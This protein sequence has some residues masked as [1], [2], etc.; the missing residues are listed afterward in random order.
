[1]ISDETLS[2]AVEQRLLMPAQVERLRAMEAET[3]GRAT[4]VEPAEDE[5]LRF[6]TGFADIFV[7]IGVILFLGALAFLM[8]AG[9]GSTP[10]FAG[11]AC[12][13]WLLAEFFTGKRRMALPSIVLLIVF[14][15]ASFLVTLQIATA[16]L[17]ASRPLPDRFWFVPVSNAAA[18]AVAAIFAVAMAAMHYVRFKVPITIAAGA[19][20]CCLLALCVVASVMPGITDTIVDFVLLVCGLAV[21][22]LGLRFDMSDPG[23]QTRRADVAFWLHLLAAPLI[24]H[25]LLALLL[26]RAGDLTT[27]AALAVLWLF[28]GLG[29]VG[30]IIDRRAIIVS[31]LLYAAVAF[32]TLIER[33]GLAGDKWSVPVVLLAIGAFILL[34]SAGWHS[35]RRAILRRLPPPIARRLPHPLA[36]SVS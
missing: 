36:L 31:G 33:Y 23:R 34:L 27:G 24:V 22:A 11:V 18:L 2:R 1:M 4:V 17:P 13:A 19:A 20:F 32:G 14:V 3:A 25:P 28:V 29:I 10:M 5:A 30:V 6:V 16:V 35:L 26:S 7:T 21:F 9:A 15:T 12:C 8:D